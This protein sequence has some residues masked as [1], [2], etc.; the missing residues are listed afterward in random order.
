[1]P[2]TPAGPLW[3]L[4]IVHIQFFH[5]LKAHHYYRTVDLHW[6]E[7]LVVPVS[8]PGLGHATGT[9]EYICVHLLLNGEKGIL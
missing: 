9:K 8:Q 3:D 2:N 7:P 6:L 4:L 5:K 1:M